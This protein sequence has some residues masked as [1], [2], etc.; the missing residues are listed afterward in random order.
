MKYLF[1][2]FISL[3]CLFS[4]ETIVF[5]GNEYKPPKVWTENGIHHGIL[6]EVLEE[7]E[8]EVQY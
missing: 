1:F 4:K 2:L 6:V 7:V 5:F 8:K 3:S